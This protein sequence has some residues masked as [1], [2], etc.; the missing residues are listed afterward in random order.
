MVIYIKTG[1]LIFTDLVDLV[2]FVIFKKT[3]KF[4][5]LLKQCKLHH[6]VS[7]EVHDGHVSKFTLHYVET[8]HGA[9]VRSWLHCSLLDGKLSC[10]TCSFCLS[11]VIDTA[12]NCSLKNRPQPIL[13]PIC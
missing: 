5:K 4:V 1:I 3:R 6:V 11:H 7:H 8:F 13:H 10:A 9:D 12:L 2:H